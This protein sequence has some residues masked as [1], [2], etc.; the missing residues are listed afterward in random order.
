MPPYGHALPS[1]L[2]LCLL[3]ALS[4][5]AC[6]LC[7]P[8]VGRLTPAAEGYG[9][10]LGQG[11]FDA[12]QQLVQ[13]SVSRGVKGHRH[14]PDVGTWHMHAVLVP[15]G[16]TES[17]SLDRV[18]AHGYLVQSCCREGVGAA[19]RALSSSSQL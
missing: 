17:G 3:C 10:G 5:L 12:E 7:V 1:N 2:L 13:T 4:S 6:L 11:H 8:T 9:H 15:L 18:M 19:Y 16:D 14:D